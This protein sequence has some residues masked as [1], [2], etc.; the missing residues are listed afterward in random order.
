VLILG[1]IVVAVLGVSFVQVWHSARARKRAE[2]AATLESHRVEA[3]DHRRIADDLAGQA[4]ALQQ[5]A[6]VEARHAQR[7]EQNAGETAR[8]LWRRKGRNRQPNRV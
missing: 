6:E 5:E 3:G 7:S 8:K 1:A 4:A 2:L